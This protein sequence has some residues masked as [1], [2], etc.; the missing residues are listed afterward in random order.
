MIEGVLL[1]RAP[2][3]SQ[4]L[5]PTRPDLGRALIV[6]SVLYVFSSIYGFAN[7]HECNGE[8]IESEAVRKNRQALRPSSVFPVPPNAR[9]RR[10]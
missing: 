10:D 6:P 4:W 1:M 7:A 2:D 9:A 8:L 3:T 5:V